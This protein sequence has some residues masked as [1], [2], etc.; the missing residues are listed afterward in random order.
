MTEFPA[1]IPAF[2]PVP[3]D[4][5]DLGPAMR[6]LEPKQRAW[7][8]A[9]HET[10]GQDNTRAAAAAGYAPGNPA[11][12]RQAGWRLAHDGKVLKAIREVAE[13]R[14]RSGALMAIETMI[15]I[16]QNP[17]HKDQFK[18]AVEVANRSGMLVINESKMVVEHRYSDREEVER[19]RKFA[20]ELGLDATK[21]LGS[22][23]YIDAEFEVV[24]DS[25]PSTA[26]LE[27]IL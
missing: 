19:V 18:A 10:G 7:V 21:L 22:V 4:D 3:D 9:F 13:G 17:T 24:Q 25:E 16:A 11:G 26:G 23:G 12:Q 1:V 8:R 15:A 2:P 6:A 14:I 5:P 27:D 20:R